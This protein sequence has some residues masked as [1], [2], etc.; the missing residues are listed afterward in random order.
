M[1]SKRVLLNKVL[2]IELSKGTVIMDAEDGHLLK[3]CQLEIRDGYPRIRHNATGKHT[4]LYQA[5]MQPTKG[6]VVD[7]MNNNRLDNRKVNLRV[8][9][10]CENARNRRGHTNRKNPYKG[11]VHDH[12]AKG[13]KKWRAYTRIMGKRHWFGYH[14]TAEEAALEYNIRARELFGD[15]ANLNVIDGIRDVHTTPPIQVLPPTSDTKTPY[16]EVLD[17]E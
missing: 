8:C 11:V 15:F 7:H 6:M 14:M 10:A 1:T 4:A 3:G 12:N 17:F 5:I 13:T 2:Y 16:G 9:T